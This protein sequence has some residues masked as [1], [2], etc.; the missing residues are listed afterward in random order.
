MSAYSQIDDSEVRAAFSAMSGRSK[1]ALAVSGGAD[2]VALMLLA[3]RWRALIGG[4]APDVTVLTVDHG[5]R[6]ESGDEA[7]WVEHLAVSMDFS[8]ATLSWDA[9]KPINRI[10]ERARTA[11]YEL[12]VDYCHR[13]GI[14]QL[15]TAHHLDDQA[16]TLL[17]RLARG[18]GVDGLA[19]IRPERQW[20]GISLLRPLL[21]MPKGRLIA[22]LKRANQ[23]WLEDPGN[24][25]SRY[26]RNRLRAAMRELQQQ[27]FDPEK[28][29]LSAKRLRRAQD[30]LEAATDDL[31]QRSLSLFDTGYC[32]LKTADFASAPTEIAMRGL[33]RALLAIGGGLEPPRLCKLERLT[34]RLGA[35]DDMVATLAGCRISLRGPVI[36]IVREKGRLGFPVMTV[37]AGDV[38]LWDHRFRVSISPTMTGTLD[39]RALGSQAFARLRRQASFGS[40]VPTDVASGLVSFWRDDRLIAVPHLGLHAD[41]NMLPNCLAENDAPICSAEFVNQAGLMGSSTLSKVAKAR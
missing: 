9:P 31:L 34:D 30:A 23:S 13:E 3:A 36:R 2:S 6:P 16:E 1:L 40:P 33:R 37:S 18:S 17:M 10:Q 8:H 19:A 20:S 41:E 12:M 29:A 4:E 26:E 38:G 15:A 35:R 32:T 22:M 28:L 11:R 5:L 25:S 27:G 39:V 21:D 7:R 24:G 14:A